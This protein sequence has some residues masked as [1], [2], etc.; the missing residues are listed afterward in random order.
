MVEA[1]ESKI[2]KVLKLLIMIIMVIVVA[3]VVW[4]QMHP[5]VEEKQTLPTDSP[6]PLV[7][8]PTDVPPKDLSEPDNVADL[9]L[10]AP[11][12]VTIVE[13]PSAD[14]GEV[15]QIVEDQTSDDSTLSLAHSDEVVKAEI[16]LFSPR[17]L[18]LLT[19]EHILRKFVRAVNALDDGGLVNQFRPFAQP[20]TPFAVEAKGAGWAIA[21]SNYKR[22]Q[23]YIDAAESLGSQRLV[24]LYL[25]YQPLLEEAFQELG[26]DKKNFDSTLKR[27]L[28]TIASAPDTDASL[29]L[30]RPSVLYQY[31]NPELESLPA[32]Q[33]LMLRIG[34][35]NRTRVRKLSKAILTELAE[36]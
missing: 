35:E 23:P 6:K 10:A 18:S 14:E 11:E 22:Y 5:V 20:A 26:V 24:Q 1:A 25:Q 31:Q 12:L 16:K 33:K 13:D 17:T 27:A 32:A 7:E 8:V 36:Q 30:V 4:W 28:E 3:V 9:V 29:A 34:Q 2:I 19:N 15:L 21:P